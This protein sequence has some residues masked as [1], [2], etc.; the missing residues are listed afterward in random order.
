M[1]VPGG[2]ATHKDIGEF[3]ITSGKFLSGESFSHVD[4]WT[5]TSEPHANLGEAWSG[6]TKFVHDLSSWCTVLDG[7]DVKHIVAEGGC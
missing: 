4:K 1:K 3:R 6:H 5:T 7:Q 2:P